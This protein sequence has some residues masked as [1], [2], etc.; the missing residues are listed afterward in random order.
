[1]SSDYSWGDSTKQDL[2]FVFVHL[3]VLLVDEYTLAPVGSQAASLWCGSHTSCV[4]KLEQKSQTWHWGGGVVDRRDS[5]WSGVA[6]DGPNPPPCPPWL[7]FDCR[8][9]HAMNWAAEP[10]YC[11]HRFAP[12]VGLRDCWT[13]MWPQFLWLMYGETAAAA[14]GMEAETGPWKLAL[15]WKNQNK[16]I[17]CQMQKICWVNELRATFMFRPS[18]ISAP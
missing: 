11:L 12:S 10:H 8:M 6:L 2:A 16:N 7:I 1:M 4:T 9:T 17:F 5:S 14:E 13:E 15:Y 18:F 3:C